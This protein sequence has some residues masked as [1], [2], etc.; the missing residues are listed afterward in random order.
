MVISIDLAFEPPGA[1]CAIGA[2]SPCGSDVGWTETL[3]AWIEHIRTDPTL[4]CPDAVR[5]TPEV[6]LG[7]QF[8]D[9]ATITHLNGTWRQRRQPTDVLS[10]AALECAPDP[11]PSQETLELG[12]I[13]ISVET[14][15]RQAFEHD[16]S[17]QR[18]LHWLVS[19]GLLHLLGWD[20]PDEAA[21]MQMLALQEQL[22]D[23]G[24]NV[25]PR[26]DVPVDADSL[27]DAH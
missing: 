13:V 18:E 25:Q 12:D 1:D 11:W 3:A 10:F 17:L 16:H 15:Q 26:A 7:L 8:T 22:L 27:R 21:L 5:Q 20:H 6:S 14:A 19:H 23:I 24:G 2:D 9:D 4:A